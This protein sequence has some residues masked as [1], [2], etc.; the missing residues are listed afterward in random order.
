MEL[1]SPKKPKK[2]K[3][4]Y[5]GNSS[6]GQ[7][8]VNKH[9]LNCI[10]ILLFNCSITFKSLRCVMI[11]PTLT[12][13]T[14]IPF[15]IQSLYSLHSHYTVYIVYSQLEQARQVCLHP[16][17]CS[18][19][20]LLIEVRLFPLLSRSLGGWGGRLNYKQFQMRFQIF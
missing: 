19:K 13:F 7:T 8:S 3:F 4:K 1:C 18:I 11:L 10:L 5:S 9:E 17:M 15:I 12:I 20:H 2:S 14:I 16:T 6:Q